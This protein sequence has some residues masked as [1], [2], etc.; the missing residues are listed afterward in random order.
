MNRC[1]LLL[2][3]I[4]AVVANGQTFRAG[5]SAPSANPGKHWAASQASENGRKYDEAI[6]EVRSY[7]QEGGDAFLA[8]TRTGWL[9]YLKGDYAGAALAYGAANKLQA[10]ALNPLLGLLNVAQAQQDLK[11]TERAAEAVLH[12]APSNYTAQMA[13]AGAYFA[14]KDFNKAGSQ[15]RRVLIFYPDD[16]DAMSSAAW[17]DFYRGSRRDAADGFRKI[18]S[19]SPEYLGA[20]T[21]LELS[22]KPVK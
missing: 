13:L 7:Q 2:I 20:S 12:V 22:Q 5:Q 14:Q 21:G 6:G 18:L 8:N 11:G 4:I 19:V 1:F 10:S 15:Y 9:K 16:V 3:P 17:S